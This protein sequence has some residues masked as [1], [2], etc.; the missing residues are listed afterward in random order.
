MSVELISKIEF[1]SHN[2]ALGL[3]FD[4]FSILPMNFF[5]NIS[6]LKFIF[7]HEKMVR[8]FLFLILENKLWYLFKGKVSE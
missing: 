5:I 4:V 6:I 2:V 1:P 8:E 7:F 3:I